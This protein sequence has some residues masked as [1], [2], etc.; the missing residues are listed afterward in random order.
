LS[1]FSEIDRKEVLT[2]GNS[3]RPS[4]VTLTDIQLFPDVRRDKGRSVPMQ[5]NAVQ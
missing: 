3:H 5:Q 1:V 4:P 2:D